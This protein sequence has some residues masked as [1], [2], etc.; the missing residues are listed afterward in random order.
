MTMPFATSR[1][2]LTHVAGRA[3]DHNDL[4]MVG[5][6]QLADALAA[7]LGVEATV[8]GHAEPALCV[9][10][11]AEL[12]AAGPMLRSVAA[13]TAEV[14]ASGQVPVTACSRCAVALATLPVVAHH[15][16]DAV[17]V[18]LDAHGDLNTPGTTTSGYLGG[19]ALSGPLGLWDSGFGAGL[20]PAHAL[21]VGARDLDPAER[22]V[23][24]RGL[25][26]LVEVGAGMAHDLRERVAGR[27]V[28]VHVDCD[29]LEPGLVP[30]D[31]VV[32]GGMTWE[33]LAAVVAVLAESEVVGVEIGELESAPGAGTGPSYVTSL[34]GALAPLLPVSPRTVGS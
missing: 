5:S 26:G 17:V 1:I 21:L 4:A 27:P 30:T 28:F 22:E 15:R 19:L 2:A 25:V 9:G 29:V 7:R 6:R 23:L 18:W 10:W 20:D 16:P 34:L 12:I 11:E 33:D 24:D 32:D 31:Y 3:G 13:R 14:F 8:V